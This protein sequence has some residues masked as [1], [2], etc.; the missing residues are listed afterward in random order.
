M[1]F[2]KKSNRHD[3]WVQFRDSH[4]ADFVAL[5]LPEFVIQT[6]DTLVEFLSEGK[7]GELALSAMSG[8]EFL[9]LESLIKVY[10]FE[11]WQQVSWTAF[12]VERFR[13]F[14]RYG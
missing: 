7:F 10:F 14:K 13:R 8:E 11:G 3:D 9:R 12:S 6:E 1:G 5:G 4:K 2:R